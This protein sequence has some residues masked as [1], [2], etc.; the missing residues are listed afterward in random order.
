[1][2]KRETDE[3]GTNPKEKPKTESKNYKYSLQSLSI[4]FFTNSGTFIVR[5]NKSSMNELSCRLSSFIK[6]ES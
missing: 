6:R 3:G 1:M 5:S 2:T 4:N